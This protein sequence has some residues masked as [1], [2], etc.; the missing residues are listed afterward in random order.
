MRSAVEFTPEQYL[1]MLDLAY[2]VAQALRGKPAT[3]KRLPDC[4]QL[5]GKLCLHA[6]TIY[7]LSQGTRA[8]IPLSLEGGASFLDHASIAVLTRAALETYLVLFEVF[9]EPASDDDSEFAHALWKLS[10]FVLRETY[11]PTGPTPPEVQALRARLQNTGRFRSLTLPQ[12]RDTL[13]GRRDRDWSAVARA[14]GFG[15][16]TLR[17][18]YKYYSGYVHADGLSGAQI[19]DADTLKVQREHAFR[20]MQVVMIVLAKMILNYADR[21]AESRQVCGKRPTTYYL[22]QIYSGAAGMAP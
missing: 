9:F 10:G 12:Q 20:H 1:E 21:F 5:G 13:R 6:L 8:P 4:Q 7:H 3:D 17:M 19:A 15:E 22:A 18:L 2:E 14:A 11:D 16:N